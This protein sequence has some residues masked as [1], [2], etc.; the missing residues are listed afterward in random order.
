MCWKLCITVL[1]RTLHDLLYHS[2]L[3]VRCSHVNT[4]RYRSFIFHCCVVFHC[5]KTQ[6]IFSPDHEDLGSFAHFIIVKSASM[7]I[8][9][10]VSWWPCVWTF[11]WGL[12]SSEGMCS[13]SPLQDVAKLPHSLYLHRANVYWALT[14]SSPDVTAELE[15]P[16]SLKWEA[17]RKGGKNQGRY[18]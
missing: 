5:V 9:L 1:L 15:E 10:H 8:L 7:N 4:C 12:P 6:F 2:T 3:F 17:E 16:S 13:S 18:K 11:L 14:M